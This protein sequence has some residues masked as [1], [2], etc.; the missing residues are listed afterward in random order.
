M[1]GRSGAR[2]MPP[3]TKTT[4]PPTPLETSQPEPTGAGVMAGDGD[5]CLADPESVQ[6]G[7]LAGPVGQRLAVDRLQLQRV[8]VAGVLPGA[9]YHE[10]AREH[11]VRPAEH[12][13]GASLVEVG[14]P[15][16]GER[17]RTCR[18]TGSARTATAGSSAGRTGS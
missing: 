15:T 1:A 14:D 13:S 3:A 7:E 10:R 11:R 9:A 17:P 12:R 8:G 2:P 16:H 4:S 6:H 5:R 18:A